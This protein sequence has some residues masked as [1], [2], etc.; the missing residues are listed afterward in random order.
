ME[1]F[2]KQFDAFDKGLADARSAR[3]QIWEKHNS[4]TNR[5]TVIETKVN[6]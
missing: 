3:S 5:V 2:A 4:L 1:T 6:N